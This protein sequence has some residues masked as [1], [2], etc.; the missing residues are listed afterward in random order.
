MQATRT[1]KEHRGDDWAPLRVAEEEE[2]VEVGQEHVPA[3]ERQ[4]THVLTLA[5]RPRDTRKDRKSRRE[6]GGDGAGQGEGA[7]T[8]EG[9]GEV[10]RARK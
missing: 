10:G 8:G 1:S 4:T 9:G 2:R 3:I 5:G 6:R 7:G